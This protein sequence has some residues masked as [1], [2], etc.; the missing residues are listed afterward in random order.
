MDSLTMAIDDD[1]IHNNNNNVLSFSHKNNK[2]ETKLT[3]RNGLSKHHPSQVGTNKTNNRLHFTQEPLN[4]VTFFNT[5]GTIVECWAHSTSPVKITWATSEGKRLSD[6]TG[7]RYIRDDG[8]LVFP[9]F[10]P[11]DYKQSIHFNQYICIATDEYGSI[12]SR[13]VT[14]KGGKYE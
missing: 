6:V 5:E 11:T 8:L 2:R 10:S 9:P 14:V 12:A 4:Q 7:L 13:L 1:W 3:H